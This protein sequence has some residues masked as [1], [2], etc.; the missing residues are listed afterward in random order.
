MQ[1]TG[2]LRDETKCHL[3]GRGKPAFPGGF[4]AQAFHS[5]FRHGCEMGIGMR[6][7]LT[8]FSSLLAGQPL[9]PTS[10][11]HLWPARWREHP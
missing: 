4:I 10:R 5:F 3:S 1:N 8:P 2:R 7:F 11:T 9:L 6:A